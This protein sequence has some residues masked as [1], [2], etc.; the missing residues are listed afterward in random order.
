KGTRH[1]L[2]LIRD[3]LFF[4]PIHSGTSLKVGLDFLNRVQRRRAVVFFFSDFVDRE[5]ERAF[6]RTGKKHDLVAVRLTDPRE[7]ELPPV[8]LLEL[9][10]AESGER[11]LLDTNSR[12]VRDAFRAQAL[13]RRDAVRQ[14]A[15]AAGVDLIEVST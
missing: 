1:V 8:G 15:R 14:L 2:R 3:V 4:R 11:L 10:D 12:P 9:E 13:A 5:Y 6:K 7:E